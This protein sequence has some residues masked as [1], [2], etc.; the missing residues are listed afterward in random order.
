VKKYLIPAV[1]ITAALAAG[2]AGGFLLGT[3][4]A[5][6]KAATKIAALKHQSALD[7]GHA[8]KQAREQGIQAGRDQER[9]AQAARED[10]LKHAGYHDS[11]ELAHSI[12]AKFNRNAKK[13]GDS[14]RVDEVSCVSQN[15]RNTD[16]V[17]L[18]EYSDDDRIT[19]KV[20]VSE[21]GNEWLSR[22]EV[23]S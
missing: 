15:V 18:T 22:G 7:V 5:E 10:D 23:Q 6:G 4:Q 16:F 20:T 3:D 8:R 17:C 21:D 1:A 14:W 2:A 13:D 11:D 19:L 9:A 12:K